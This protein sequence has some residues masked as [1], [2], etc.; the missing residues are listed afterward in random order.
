[1]NHKSLDSMCSF[2][3]CNKNPKIPKIAKKMIRNPLRSPYGLSWHS[4]EREDLSLVC[5]DLHNHQVKVTK[6]KEVTE[7]GT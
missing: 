7:Y 3:G 4:L 6:L 1:M 2:G 5:D